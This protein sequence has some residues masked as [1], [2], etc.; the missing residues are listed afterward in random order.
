MTYQVSTLIRAQA[1]NS[2]KA[3]SV[4][5]LPASIPCLTIRKHLPLHGRTVGYNPQQVAGS[6]PSVVRYTTYI[7]HASGLNAM[8]SGNY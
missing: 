3:C 5:N 4:R 7:A 1:L 8:V 2:A 6:P